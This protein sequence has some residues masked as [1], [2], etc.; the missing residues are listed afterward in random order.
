[1]SLLLLVPFGLCGQVNGSGVN[2]YSIATYGLDFGY[3]DFIPLFTADQFN[4]T[5]WASLYKR[6]GARYAGPVAEHADGFAMYDSQLS[7]YTA[8]KMGP[9]RDI[10]GE[11]TAAVR[12]QGMK[13]I[14]S[15]HHMVGG[16]GWLP[17]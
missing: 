8:V 12:A 4:A 11:V 16:G 9:K 2:A 10:A 1:M 17:T 14:N 15:L 7:N 3:K 5:A 6:A 13:V